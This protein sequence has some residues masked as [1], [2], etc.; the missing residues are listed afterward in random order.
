MK[1]YIYIT[2]IL[3]FLGMLGNSIYQEIHKKESKS[4]RLV[5]HKNSTVFER[6]FKP[7]ELIDLQKSIKNGNI[8]VTTEIEKS[9]YMNSTLFQ[10]LD[11]NK[12]KNDFKRLL[13]GTNQNANTLVNILIYEN[14]K[15]DPGKKNAKAKLY[16]GYLVF[17]FSVNNK[18]I[19][20]LQ[21]DFFDKKGKDIPK[22]LECGLQSI[23]TLE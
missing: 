22:I 12:V 23:L 5:C 2:I 9:K 15:K 14:D 19:Y 21:I 10:Y 8:K 17:S 18:L 6:V 3:L 11:Q 1:K 7:K 4:A 16:A 13:V 20:K